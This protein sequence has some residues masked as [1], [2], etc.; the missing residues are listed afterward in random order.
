MDRNGSILI[1]YHSRDHAT[2]FPDQEQNIDLIYDDPSDDQPTQI[3]YGPGYFE[4]YHTL[5]DIR[6]IHGLNL[7]ESDPAQSEAAA[8]EACRSI[9]SNLHLFELGNEFNFG[10]FMYRSMNYTIE[11]YVQEWNSK[12]ES[13]METVEEACG[14]FPGL[15]AP[16]FFLLDALDVESL[17]DDVGPI[18]DNLGGAIP[19]SGPDT[20]LD[21]VDANKTAQMLFSKGYDE[22][23]LTKELSF[24]Q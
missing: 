22:K 4:S 10:F 11:D 1:C 14:D 19:D 17:L 7:N 8:E 6:F 5:G 18:L 9:G 3:N 20:L 12:T 21:W 13:L 23:N 24:H 16:S 2:Y 15:M